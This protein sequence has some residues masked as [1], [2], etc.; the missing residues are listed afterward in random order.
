MPTHAN[1]NTPEFD[2]TGWCIDGGPAQDGYA[3]RV[4]II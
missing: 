2:M 1:S 3:E 4:R